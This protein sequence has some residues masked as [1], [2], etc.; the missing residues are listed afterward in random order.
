MN[1]IYLLVPLC[2]LLIFG[3]IYWN[4]NRNYEAAIAQKAQDAANAKVAQLKKDAELKLIAYKEAAA[5]SEKRKAERAIKDKREEDE[6]QARIDLD[7][8]R[9]RLFEESKR[10]REQVDVLKKELETVKAEV[11]K[12]D[13]QKSQ[14]E[15]E[16]VFLAT[17]TKKADENAK[18]YQQLLDKLDAAD[19]ARAEAARVAAAAAAAAARK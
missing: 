6:K 1:K 17:Y 16:R 4:F 5:E 14:L 15:A 9:L 3:T 2:G 8:K 7:D 19:K 12:I 10:N 11:T 13:E 18:S